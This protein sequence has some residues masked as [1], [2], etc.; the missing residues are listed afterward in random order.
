[1]LRLD[2]FAAPAVVVECELSALLREP[3]GL[4]PPAIVGTLLA[5]QQRHAP[6][7]LFTPERQAAERLALRW[8]ARYDADVRDGKRPLP[9]R[10]AAALLAEK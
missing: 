10:I 7:W 2:A 8:L 9:E 6:R 5:W 4:K 3:G 1:M